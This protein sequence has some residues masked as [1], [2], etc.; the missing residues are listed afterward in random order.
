MKK[1]LLPLLIIFLLSS[2]GCGGGGGGGC[3]EEEEQVSADILP[4][5]VF[6]SISG[7]F[8]E[9]DLSEID[10][11]YDSTLYNES[12][13]EVHLD[14]AY[15][16]FELDE[17]DEDD[18]QLL[19]YIFG[20]ANYRLVIGQALGIRPSYFFGANVQLK[21]ELDVFIYDLDD[22]AIGDP[23]EIEDTSGIEQLFRDEDYEGA[24][25]ALIELFRTFKD[26]GKINAVAGFNP[27]RSQ[28]SLLLQDFINVF[29]SRTIQ[30]SGGY[31][32]ITSVVDSSDTVNDGTLMQ[33][34]EGICKVGGEFQ[35]D[36][37]TTT[38]EGSYCLPTVISS[39][40]EE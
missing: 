32:T 39:E 18:V 4:C 25:N 17:N 30:A 14:E 21:E 27:D 7:K 26:D 10:L 31:V 24:L 37:Q 6:S 19:S 8:G 35:I 11:A 38:A 5:E 2:V 1:K 22:Y 9:S 3:G 34:Y 36:F 29:S 40:P 16:Y 20:A 28:D 23:L 13:E 12:L 15:E 33:P